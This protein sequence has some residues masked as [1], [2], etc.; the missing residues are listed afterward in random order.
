MTRFW[1]GIILLLILLGSS[2]GTTLAIPAFHSRLSQDL[3]SAGKTVLSG[4][5]EKAT[6][7]ADS[8]RAK[9]ERCRHFVAST[10]DHEPLEQMD[11]LF[12]QLEVYQN[13]LLPGDYAAVCIHLSQL[14]QA[15]G[16]SQALNWWNI[17]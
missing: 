1:I 2:I 8:A 9:W 6:A 12:S 13:Q 14:S 15:I 17:L 3:E 10:V 16:E 4:D 11:S 5:W 7:L